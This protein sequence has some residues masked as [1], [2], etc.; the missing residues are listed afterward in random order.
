MRAGNEG[1]AYYEMRQGVAIG[2]LA[3]HDGDGHGLRVSKSRRGNQEMVMKQLC[4]FSDRHA[5][6]IGRP[7]M[8][9][10]TSGS[11]GNYVSKNSTHSLGGNWWEWDERDRGGAFDLRV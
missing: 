6:V 7:D 8:P 9:V 2:S 11:L 5:V 4:D 1:S 3:A 10:L